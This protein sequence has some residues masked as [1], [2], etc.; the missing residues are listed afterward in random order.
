M[1][2]SLGLARREALWALKA[3]RDEPLGLFA[4]ASRR[5]A[6]TVEEVREPQ[7]ALR[8]MPPAVKSSRT[9]AMSA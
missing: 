9:T 2:E 1:N 7:V 6:R 8:P 5:E 4:A 3:L